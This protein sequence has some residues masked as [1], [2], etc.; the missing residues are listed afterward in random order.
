MPKITITS[1][2][3]LLLFQVSHY[4][5]R[6]AQARNINERIFLKAELYNFK[7]SLTAYLN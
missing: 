5:Q 7:Q 3:H 6:V 1:Q 4:S 2:F